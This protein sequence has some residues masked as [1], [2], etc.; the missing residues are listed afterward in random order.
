MHNFKL[1]YGDYIWPEFTSRIF[2]S[3]V[4]IVS[5]NELTMAQSIRKGL[6]KK[7]DKAGGY[8][9][10]ASHMRILITS[11]VKGNI[12]S[13]VNILISFKDHG[14]MV[15]AD[16]FPYSIKEFAYESGYFFAAENVLI[17]KT[18][19][20]A[21]AIYPEGML[22]LLTTINDE[23]LGKGMALCKVLNTPKVKSRFSKS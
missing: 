5:G 20:D 21:L 15:H 4:F 12:S 22:N 13:P 7:I 18:R 11:E 1:V 8:I 9:T 10:T 2:I 23:S 19:K 3:P 17:A 6:V 16:L 14:S